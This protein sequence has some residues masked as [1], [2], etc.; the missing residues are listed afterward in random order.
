[1]NHPDLFESASAEAQHLARR[2]DPTTSHEAAEDAV[3]SGLVR[4]EEAKI[5]EH[6]RTCCPGTGRTACEIEDAT[7]IRAHRRMALL[8]RKGKVQRNG[9]STCEITGKHATLWRLT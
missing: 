7:G 3:E 6:L 8:E 4:G 1:M 2:L 9:T 5:L